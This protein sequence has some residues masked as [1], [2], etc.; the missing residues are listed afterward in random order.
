MVAN[1]YADLPVSAKPPFALWKTAPFA[2]SVQSTSRRIRGLVCATRS[3]AGVASAA[4]VSGI[5]PPVC[6]RMLVMRR[7]VGP[8][9]R[10]PA[11]DPGPP[12]AG[13]R[14]IPGRRG[15]PGEG[16]QQLVHVVAAVGGLDQQAGL[17]QAAEDLLARRRWRG[18][19]R[20]RG[21]GGARD[22]RRL[23]PAGFQVVP[24]QD[25]LLQQPEAGARVHAEL[26]AQVPGDPLV[27]GQ[28]LAP[29]ATPVQRLDQ[30]LPEALVERVG[31]RRRPQLREHLPTSAG[32]QLQVE[33]L[34]QGAQPLLLQ[35]R[36]VLPVQQL[37]LHVG[38]RRAAPQRERGPQQPQLRLR[39]GALRRAPEQVAEAGEVEQ[40]RVG[41]HPVAAAGDRL[42]RVRGDPVPREE[43]AQPQHAGLQRR[44]GGAG[45]LLAPDPPLQELDGHHAAGVQQQGG[46]QRRRLG[47]LQHHGGRVVGDAERPQ[48]QE[49]GPPVAGRLIRLHLSPR[50][51]PGVRE[52]VHPTA[53]PSARRAALRTPT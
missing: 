22:R 41:G 14:R 51:R 18:R 44:L 31:L 8:P 12:H 6:G 34:F 20:F 23:G 50:L 53:T 42:D 33:D 5:A 17:D 21:G 43:P 39:V 38:Q 40:R 48:H 28:R 47:R 45:L 24:P 52:L 30:L 19:L 1:R 2:V 26:L 29:P 9:R 7:P 10:R 46:E 11:P 35:P 49:S 4:A 13:R 15:A 36:H 3:Y 32:R 16:P 37:G 27:L 25:G